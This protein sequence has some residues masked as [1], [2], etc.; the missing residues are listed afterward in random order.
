MDFEWNEEKDAVLRDRYGIG[1]EE[2]VTAVRSGL[3]IADLKHPNRMRYPNQRLLIL[4]IND[5]A[6][7]VPYVR[8]GNTLFLKTLFPNR[9]HT[10]RYL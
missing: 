5:Y 7:D 3:L 10:A 1:F 2:C 4:K 6:W 9:K 8:D